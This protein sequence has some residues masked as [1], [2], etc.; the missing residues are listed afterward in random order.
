MREPRANV[1]RVLALVSRATYSEI[2][3]QNMSAIT[4]CPDAVGWMQVMS[5]QRSASGPR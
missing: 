2:T 4:W 3:A 1:L 5:I